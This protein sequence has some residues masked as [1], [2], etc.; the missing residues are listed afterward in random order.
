MGLD[1]LLP[2][3]TVIPGLPFRRKEVQWGGITGFDGPPKATYGETF[4]LTV[5]EGP[6]P[7][8]LLH[9]IPAP[10]AAIEWQLISIWGKGLD[11]FL[12][13]CYRTADEESTTDDDEMEDAPPTL[14]EL[15]RLLCASGKWILLWD[16]EDGGFA[17]IKNGTASDV[18]VE[19]YY[20][21][22]SYYEGFMICGEGCDLP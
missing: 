20:S 15:L 7:E 22:T 17:Y 12:A 8:F 21:H 3:G 19:L 18:L 6:T 13:T 9:K 11:D 14:P 2:R 4:T 1:I 5:Y 16:R 10:Y